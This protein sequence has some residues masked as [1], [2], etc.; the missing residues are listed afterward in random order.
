MS[1][2]FITGASRGFG[3]EVALEALRRG[4]QVVATARNTEALQHLVDLAGSNVLALPLDVTVPEQ[5]T[6]AVA[7]ERGPR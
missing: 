4:D 3:R 2:W 6:A 5:I 7:R 1:V